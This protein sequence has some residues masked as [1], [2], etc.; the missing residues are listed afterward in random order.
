MAWTSMH[1]AV[2]MTGGALLG[3]TACVIRGRGWRFLPLA[4]TIGGVWACLPDAT[5]L[6]TEDFPNA[7]FAAALGQPALRDWL[8]AHAD[9]FFFHGRLDAQP[10]ELALHGLAAIILLYNLA[11]LPV[12]LR[13]RRRVPNTSENLHHH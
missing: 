5:R 2:G 4:M 13:R 8:R 10:R 11:L 3:A 12:W 9:W 7:P 1:F 6:F